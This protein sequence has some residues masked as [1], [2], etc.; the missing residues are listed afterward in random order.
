MAIEQHHRHRFIDWVREN[1][2]DTDKLL[3]TEDQLKSYINKWTLTCITTTTPTACSNR[4]R[5]CGCCTAGES[6]YNLTVTSGVAGA[7]YIL[8]EYAAEV[9]F[10]EYADGAPADPADGDT[11]TVT[12][13][14]VN[15]CALM[16]E[17]FLEL[18]SNHAKLTIYY[19]MTGMAMSLKDLSDAFYKQSVRWAAEALQC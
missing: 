7:T 1:L 8:D 16:S 13:F 2:G 19:N 15:R 12:F 18:S 11:I 10:D 14:R 9:W 17:L 5:I 3:F 4:F 6:I